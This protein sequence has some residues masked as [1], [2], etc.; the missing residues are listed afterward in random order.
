MTTITAIPTD[1]N[2]TPDGANWVAEAARDL[3]M[4]QAGRKR[5]D[6]DTW[7]LAGEL[8][9]TLTT[10][11][12]AVESMVALNGDSSFAPTDATASA[13]LTRKTIAAEAV[14][15][16]V[17]KAL[18]LTGGAGLYRSLGLERLLRDLHGARFHPLP[19]RRQQRFTGRI[20]LGLS[21]DR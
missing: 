8:E 20:A 15:A 4:Q 18:E 11:Q 14:L 19:A 1:A 5:D 17:E 9:N 12:I 2:N 10:A 21:P 3:A 7:Y 16:T 13:I 6:S